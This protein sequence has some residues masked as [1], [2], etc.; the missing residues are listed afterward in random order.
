MLTNLGVPKSASFHFVRHIGHREF[1]V[2]SGS[3]PGDLLKLLLRVVCCG[4]CIE[5]PR[6]DVKAR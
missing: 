5:I 4:E 1:P 6:V 2:V 3:D